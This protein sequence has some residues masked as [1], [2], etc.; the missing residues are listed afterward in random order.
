MTAIPPSIRWLPRGVFTLFLA[1]VTT[2]PFIHPTAA[3][4]AAIYAIDSTDTLFSFT[5]DGAPIARAK[6]SADVSSLCGGGMA[7]AGNILYVTLC[8]PSSVAAFDAT[9]LQPV[10]LSKTAFQGLNTP[11][12]IAYDQHNQGLYIGNGGPGNPARDFEFTRRGASRD[13]PGLWPSTYGSSGMA[14]DP[15]DNTIWISNFFGAAWGGPPEYGVGEYNEDGSVAT[16]FN[17]ATQFVPPTDISQE[18]PYTIAFCPTLT[19]ARKNVVVVGFTSVNYGNQRGEVQSYTTSGAPAGPPFGG[20]TNANGLS[21]WHSGLV[22]VADQ[23]G[24]LLYSLKGERQA[25]P[26]GWFAGM[27][28]PIFGVLAR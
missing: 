19:K 26:A 8:D 20:I 15:A 13:T 2:L 6:L 23:G 11:R 16:N 1:G 7:I 24:L 12:G 5:G 21:C 3:H 27:A 4:A 28:P 9:T 18:Q 17:Y 14:W 10:V 25:I 22:F